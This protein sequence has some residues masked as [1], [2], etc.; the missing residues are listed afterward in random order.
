LE[1]VP[2]AGAAHLEQLDRQATR[3]NA[4]HRRLG[5]T[6]R[7][8]LH[9]LTDFAGREDLD[10]LPAEKQSILSDEVLAFA[11]SFGRYDRAWRSAE[12]PQLG[13]EA[14]ASLR[15]ALARGL[16]DA[17]R[18]AGWSISLDGIRRTTRANRRRSV[19]LYRIDPVL[20]TEPWPG[21]RLALLVAADLLE[22]EGHRLARCRACG[23]LFVREK[24]QRWCASASC[25]R[26]ARRERMKR[27]LAQPRKRAQVKRR[28]QQRY[29]ERKRQA[30]EERRRRRR[31]LTTRPAAP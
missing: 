27:Y 10:S 30:E 16:Q 2:A 23:R 22:A 1:P 12:L 9:W 18:G 19:I 24:G 6:I 17:L 4:A 11:E 15:L 5:G 3:L 13:L 31:V 26:V 28:R 20:T 29:A 14:L 25:Q 8:R 21:E 7:Q